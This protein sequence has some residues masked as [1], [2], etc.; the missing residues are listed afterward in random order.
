MLPV[1]ILLLFSQHFPIRTTSATGSRVAFIAQTS[2]YWESVE[3]DSLLFTRFTDC[4][5]TDS[6]GFPELPV[7]TCL[8][9]VPDSV[10]PVLE[11][12]FSGEHEQDVDPVHPAPAHV[13]SYLGTPAVA[14]SF[15]QDSTAYASSEFWPSHRVRIFGETRICDQRLLQVQ[16][17]P[18]LYRAS[19]STLSTV[20]SI[21]VSVAFDSATAVWNDSG[22]GRFQALVRGSSILGYHSVP[23]THSP[24]TFFGEVDPEDGPSRMPDY[25]IVCASGLY[26]Q[27]SDAIDSLAEH[28]VSLNRFDVALVTTDAI[29]ED[30]GGSDTI[31]T[32][33]ILRDFTEHM[34]ENWGQPTSKRP[35]YLL[36]IGDH[37]DPSF[38]SEP[39]FLP[40]HEYNRGPDQ[41]SFDFDRIGNDEWYAYFGEDRSVNN[42][43]PDMIVG[44]L[45]VKNGEN[46]DTLSVIIQSLISLESPVQQ[47]PIPDY[48]RRILRLTGTGSDDKYNMPHQLPVD[49]APCSLWTGEFC[50][51]LGYDYATHYCGDGRDFTDDDG[52]EL[53]SWE[54]RDFCLQEFGRGAGVAFYSDHGDV[55]MLSAGLEWWPHYIT[56]DPHTKGSLDS[57]FNNIQITENLEAVQNHSPPFVLLLSCSSGTFNHT[58]ERHREREVWPELCRFAGCPGCGT[59]WHPPVEAYDF[60]TDCLAEVLLKH[61]DVPVAGVFAGSLPSAIGCYDDYGTGILEA[62]YSLGLSRLGDAVASA[63]LRRW[64]SFQL[65]D[66]GQFNLLGDP[67]LDMGDRIRFPDACDLL[68][69]PGEVQVSLYPAETSNGTEL[70][71]TFTVRNNGAVDYGEFDILVSFSDGD[72]LS[73]VI[74]LG[75]SLRADEEAEYDYVWTCPQWFDTPLELT[76][77]V[78]ADYLVEC[79]DCWRH[80]NT[81]EVKVQLNDTFPFEEGWPVQ[82]DGVVGTTPMLVNLDADP[83]LEVV[84]LT[85]TTLQ[86]FDPNGTELWSLSGEGFFGGIHPLAADLDRDDEVELMLASNEGIKV[87]NS[88]GEMIG[89]LETTGSVFVAGDMHLSSGLEVCVAKEDSLYLYEWDSGE[90]EFTELGSRKLGSAGNWSSQSL[91]CADLNG[92]AYEDVVLCLGKNDFFPRPDSLRAVIAYNWDSDS[93]LY[94]ETWEG[95]PIVVFPAAGTLA[96]MNMIGY[97]LKTYNPLS[98][99]PALL[100]EP[101]GIVEENP[102]EPGTVAAR[103]L[104]YGV[105]ADWDPFVPGLDAFILPSEMEGLAWDYQGDALDDWPTL[106]F[107]GSSYASPISPTALGDLD[108]S[109]LADVLFCTKLDGIYRVMAFNHEGDNLAGFHITL[110]DNVSAL[111]GFA[112]GD[113]GRDGTIEIVFGTSDGLLHCWELGPCTAGYTP[114]PQFQQNHGRTGTLE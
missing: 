44:R 14:D 86:A 11:F 5:V 34:W 80:N 53:S 97:P 74:I 114:W 77:T 113:I 109:G 28:R 106:P 95:Y 87:V 91:V 39:W 9:A 58:V 19:D 68:V 107:S 13:I 6:T 63:R 75:D 8:V 73:L 29:M 85:G 33:N 54:W 66:I 79:N 100:I 40:T 88:E 112:V 83:A 82:A 41:S 18:A 59:P 27:C 92:G 50:Q 21:S 84:A 16:L 24:P 25:L 72:S 89:I 48:R 42:A 56:P 81:A 31:L 43:F 20:N 46:A 76:V 55:H 65:D 10:V 94:S 108:D 26:D 69:Y 15:V 2:L 52:S 22:L 12:A 78:E 1:F 61:T 70:P 90:G 104:Q 23:Q 47:V 35:G 30:F 103:S 99:N 62:V 102:C 96:G 60:G 17:F 45:S 101:G 37:E 67:A 49:W 3:H 105:F 7:I 98:D 71:M 38:G 36:L 110:P 32:D 4:S 111:G 64:S 93:V 57:T 51:W